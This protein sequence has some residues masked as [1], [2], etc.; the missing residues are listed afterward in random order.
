[1]REGS[2]EPGSSAGVNIDTPRTPGLDMD[3]LGG[4]DAGAD[5]LSHLLVLSSAVANRPSKDQPV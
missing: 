1:M 2:R 4:D 5:F 3:K